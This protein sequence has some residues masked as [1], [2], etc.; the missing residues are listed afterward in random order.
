MCH[1]GMCKVWTCEKHDQR[2]NTAIF[3]KCRRTSKSMSDRFNKD[4]I[5][6]KLND[7]YVI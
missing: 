4:D 7:I 2:A 3:P 1:Q 6:R 5:E